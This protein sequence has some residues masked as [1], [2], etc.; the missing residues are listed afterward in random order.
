[1]IKIT[2]YSISALICLHSSIG[3]AANSSGNTWHDRF[4]ESLGNIPIT[5][6]EPQGGVHFTEQQLGAVK[7]ALEYY[8]DNT[9]IQFFSRFRVPGYAHFNG[10]DFNIQPIFKERSYSGIGPTAKYS[11]I[12]SSHCDLRVGSGLENNTYGRS[13]LLHELMHSIGFKHEQQRV[14]RDSELYTDFDGFGSVEMHLNFDIDSYLTSINV[15][16]FDFE[17][18]SLYNSKSL[19]YKMTADEIAE[20][21]AKESSSD[22]QFVRIKFTDR[23]LEMKDRLAVQFNGNNNVPSV[24]RVNP[25]LDWND[26]NAQDASAVFRLENFTVDNYFNIKHS[27]NFYLKDD[28]GVISFEQRA[29]APSSSDFEWTLVDIEGGRHAIK[30][31]SSGRFIALNSSGLITQSELSSLSD[32]TVE[33]FLKTLRPDLS[34]GD[35]VAINAAY[36]FPVTINPINSEGDIGV[37][38]D[39]TGYQVGAILTSNSGETDGHATWYI[40]R[41]GDENSPYFS[42]RNAASG[43]YLAAWFTGIQQLKTLDVDSQVPAHWMIEPGKDSFKLKSRFG[44]KYL[45]LEDGDLI[46]SDAGAL[47]TSGWTISKPIEHLDYSNL[48]NQVRAGLP[49]YFLPREEGDSTIVFNDGEVTV[50]PISNDSSVAAGKWLVE[51]IALNNFKFFR[52]RNA[53]SGL[54]LHNELGSIGFSNINDKNSDG[55]RLVKWESAQ[56]SFIKGDEGLKIKNRQSNEFLTYAQ[57]LHLSGDSNTIGTDWGVGQTFGMINQFRSQ[58]DQVNSPW[59]RAENNFQIVHYNGGSVSERS[60]VLTI[61][62]GLLGIEKVFQSSSQDDRDASR[63]F[64]FNNSGGE[65]SFVIQN[66]QD[67]SV[68]FGIKHAISVEGQDFISATLYDPEPGFDYLNGLKREDPKLNWVIEFYDDYFQIRNLD[69]DKYLANVS[70][71]PALVD[72]QNANTTRW[73]LL[74]NSND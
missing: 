35:V 55:E 47:V 34:I 14:D 4:P 21:Y 10:E 37:I 12:F 40:E 6:S 73:V 29:A 48:M 74:H 17:S 49:V 11:S 25:V 31:R 5:Y 36:H 22:S 2:G 51:P 63:W 65:S 46:L 3:F 13:T 57:E 1:M 15:G 19:S 39:N 61:R 24:N 42:I 52:I 67:E 7:Y 56:W 54:Y 70:G 43:S 30:N 20:W 60:D 53:V 66:I 59:F 9:G 72:G 33:P 27:N 44:E 23:S 16:A 8:E 69:N 41:V 68:P 62:D 71:V 64:F 38:E 32:W 18:I 58:M 45:I 50:E 26:S 28:S